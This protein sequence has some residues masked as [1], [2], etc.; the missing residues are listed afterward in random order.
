MNSVPHGEG[1]T[2]NRTERAGMFTKG[3]V[4]VRGVMCD[5]NDLRDVQPWCALEIGMVSLL[6]EFNATIDNCLKKKTAK[7]KDHVI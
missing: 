3:S 1:V 5:C 6:I 4:S 2:E 7:E